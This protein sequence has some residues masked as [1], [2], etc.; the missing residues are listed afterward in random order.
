MS[1]G[2]KQ[3]RKDF[4]PDVD[5]LGKTRLRMLLPRYVNYY[6]DGNDGPEEIFGYH[7][8]KDIGDEGE[9]DARGPILEV[10]E[11]VEGICGADSS[12]KTANGALGNILGGK[13]GGL[14][15]ED[16]SFLVG[17]LSK[18]VLA[19]AVDEISPVNVENGDALPRRDFER[20]LRVLAKPGNRVAGD[21]YK[22]SARLLA[23]AVRYGDTTLVADIG[24][25][26]DKIKSK[27]FDSLLAKSKD[28]VDLY[29][30]RVLKEDLCCAIEH[31]DRIAVV[32]YLGDIT[33]ESL[34]VEENLW[35]MDLPLVEAARYG[36]VAVAASLIKQGA[37]IDCVSK[38]KQGIPAGLN[39]ASVALYYGKPKFL[40]YAL[41]LGID[42][43]VL[44]A[45]KASLGNSSV[46]ED[47]E[48]RVD[49]LLGRGHPSRRPKVYKDD[50][51]LVEA[52]NDAKKSLER[53]GTRLPDTA[54]DR[55]LDE[56]QKSGRGGPF[57]LD[58]PH[59]M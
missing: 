59:A 25:F 53:V 34:N 30:K 16:Y 13:H 56:L 55:D 20:V 10:R 15:I 40:K 17:V 22:R 19:R 9:M 54:A 33:P 58:D 28:V 21:E 52:F 45:E 41:S 37:N 31:G 26:F 14:D 2:K 5:S 7:V 3:P 43:M 38:G 51:L 29:E 4:Y 42:P 24:G 44:M 48:T 27:P 6:N 11:L 12:L 1:T 32:N 47:V 39:I 23:C 36:R 35:G 49:G 46:Y 8:F 50:R 57:S 18:T